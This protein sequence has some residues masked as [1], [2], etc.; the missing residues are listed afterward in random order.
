MFLLQSRALKTD[1]VTFGLG[2]GTKNPEDA[3]APHQ[4]STPGAAQ[5]TWLGLSSC[6]PALRWLCRASVQQKLAP[7]TSAARAS[8]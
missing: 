3:S 5:V 4:I 1:A 6:G 8:S 2:L 7:D